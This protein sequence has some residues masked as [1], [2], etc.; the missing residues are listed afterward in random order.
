MYFNYFNLVIVLI[1]LAVIKGYLPK[2]ECYYLK[3]N[4]K[5][6][7]QSTDGPYTAR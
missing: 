4:V 1:E 3:I 2:F 7:W 6:N 5:I